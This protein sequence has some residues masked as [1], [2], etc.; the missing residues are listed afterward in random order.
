MRF[1]DNLLFLPFMSHLDVLGLGIAIPIL[2]I[3]IVAFRLY[4]RKYQTG[5]IGVDDC[6]AAATLVF[7]IGMSATIIIGAKRGALG[8]VTEPTPPDLTDDELLHYNNS[9]S[10]TLGK[11]TFAFQLLMVA[12]YASV[13]LSIIF[14]Y[15]RIFIVNHKASIGIISTVIIIVVLCWFVTF[16]LLFIFGCGTHVYANWGTIADT[17]AYC[18]GNLDYEIEE[19]MAISDLILDLVIFVFP[20]HSIWKLQLNTQRKF[21]IS[22]IFLIGLMAIV[23]SVLRLAYYEQDLH[24]LAWEDEGL[25]DPCLSTTT[26]LWWSHLEGGLSLIAACLP[27]MSYLLKKRTLKS[28][29]SSTGRWLSPQSIRSHLPLTSKARRYDT[30]KGK[31]PHNNIDENVSLTRESRT[32]SDVILPVDDNSYMETYFMQGMN[33]GK[34]YVHDVESQAIPNH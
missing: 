1:P 21:G 15:R 16:E 4:V 18:H 19:A 17:V 27:S 28:V 20:F 10:I 24:H 7:I 3:S 6:L 29:T 2:C 22:S 25:I 23:A 33:K 26:A 34:S 30:H 9:Q 5:G 13:K 31:L 11:I 12:A 32:V 14:F 8:Y